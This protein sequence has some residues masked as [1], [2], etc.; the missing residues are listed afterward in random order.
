M[1]T[2]ISDVITMFVSEIAGFRAYWKTEMIIVM[3]LYV[4][5]E[6]RSIFYM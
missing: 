3:L 1:N 5:N 4:K 6:I 2:W